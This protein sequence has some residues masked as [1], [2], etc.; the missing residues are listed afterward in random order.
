MANVTLPARGATGSS[1]PV[2]RTTTVGGAEVQHV[3]L[4]NEAGAET[5]V[6]ANPM[7]VK[8]AGIGETTDAKVQSDANGSLVAFLRGIVSWLAELIGTVSQTPTQT[9]AIRVQIGPGDVISSLP[10]VVDY[11]HH[12]VHE[13][14]A[15]IFSDLQTA[16]L[17]ATATRDIR[18]SVGALDATTK[19]PHLVIEFIADAMAEI[20]LYEGTTWTSGGT[21]QAGYNRNRNVADDTGTL[22]VDGGTALTVNAIGTSVWKGMTTGAKNSA[23]GTDR[24]AYEF[25]LKPNTEYCVRVTSRTAG[26]KFLTRLEYYKDLGV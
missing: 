7:S 19:T 11:P 26:L 18:I 9:K 24:G 17:N 3:R 14:E 13:G 25:V 4:T 10:I 22:Y 16:G 15:F 21:S 2:V 6:V 20:E 1:L 8:A 12:Q 5:G 23:G